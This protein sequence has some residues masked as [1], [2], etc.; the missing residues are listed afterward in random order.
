ALPISLRP[1]RA[2]GPCGACRTGG[3]GGACRPALTPHA[4][5]EDVG[6]AV[7]LPAGLTMIVLP[8][9]DHLDQAV[10]LVHAHEGVLEA[11]VRLERS[12]ECTGADHQDQEPCCDC[13]P[14]QL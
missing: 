11:L 5:A 13:P 4:L 12:S 1:L 14:L 8:A 10:L 3:A 9:G 7:P 6:H 2:H